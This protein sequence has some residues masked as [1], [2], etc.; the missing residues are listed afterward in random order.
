MVSMAGMECSVW[1]PWDSLDFMDILKL[2]VTT[3]CGHRTVYQ[4][5]LDFS[6]LHVGFCRL[7]VLQLL[8]ESRN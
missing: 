4:L 1:C 7:L 5:D 8:G 2:H 6:A 3:G